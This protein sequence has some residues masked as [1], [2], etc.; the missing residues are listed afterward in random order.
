M[1]TAVREGW[2]AYLN[3][4]GPTNTVMQKINTAMDAQTFTDASEAQRALVVTDETKLNGLGTM[5][6]ARWQQLCDQLV[7]LKV[8]EKAPPAAECFKVLAP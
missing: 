2:H 4:P 5:T 3:D 1:V 7:E 8:I 6:Q